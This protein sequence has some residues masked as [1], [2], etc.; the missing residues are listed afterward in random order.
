[1]ICEEKNLK[2]LIPGGIVRCN[3]LEV[4]VMYVYLSRRQK[5]VV[6]HTLYASRCTGHKLLETTAVYLRG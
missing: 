1:M 6:I 3:I 2:D 5:S 4:T